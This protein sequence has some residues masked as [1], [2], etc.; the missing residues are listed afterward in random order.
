MIYEGTFEAERLVFTEVGSDIEHWIMLSKAKDEPKFCV[1]CCCNDEWIWEFWYNKSDY[2]RVKFTVMGSIF[3][4]ETTAELMNDLDSIFE[5]NFS[6][7]V[8]YDEEGSE[9]DG[10]CEECKYEHTDCCDDFDEE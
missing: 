6:D 5:E 7:I 10:N 1:T 8:A 9:C 2:E 3:R 4:C